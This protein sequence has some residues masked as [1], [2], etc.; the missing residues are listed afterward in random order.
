MRLQILASALALSGSAA[1]FSDSWPL[2]MF[3]TSKFSDAPSN[4]HIQTRSQ[5]L[6]QVQDLLTSCPTDNYVLIAHEG[7]NAA[8]LRR[9][10]SMPN[11]HRAIDRK[12]IQGKLIV[13]EVVGESIDA[14]AI[15]DYIKRAC[16]EQ[17]KKVK[18]HFIVIKAS[19]NEQDVIKQW[20]ESEQWLND[21][22]TVLFVGTPSTKAKTA[23]SKSE[24]TIY[25]P[26][27]IEPLHM[28][29]KR[30]VSDNA[31]K[32]GNATRDTRGLFEKYQ[33]FTPGI[34]M[35]I[36]AAIVLFSLLGVGLRALASLEVSYGAFEK[37][38]GPAAQ[39]KQQ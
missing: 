11:L 22:Y 30:D 21:S 10:N 27:F 24:K 28:D 1:A 6:E 9:P 8:D 31:E 34:F 29:L 3:S 16:Y 14:P 38:M 4:N 2:V 17:A 7:V 13:P 15:Q 39:K 20:E 23:A 12:E 32:P 36:I 19:T 35:G 25:E 5:A 26:E 18:P 37:D 33:F